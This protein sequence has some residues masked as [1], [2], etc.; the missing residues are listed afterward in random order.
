VKNHLLATLAYLLP[1]FPLGYFWHLTFFSNYYKSLEIYRDD[2]IIP[3]GLITMIIQAVIWSYVYKHLFGG[4]PVWRGALKFALIAAPLTWS[5]AVLAVAAKNRMSS[6][7]G[8]VGIETAFTVLQFAIVSPLIA[9]AH[10][11]S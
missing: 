9:W 6:V 3:F 7:P 4:E 5:L 2:M 11:D 1:T 10:S 8:F